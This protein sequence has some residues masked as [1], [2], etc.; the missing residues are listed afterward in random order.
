MN[1]AISLVCPQRA[2]CVLA[3]FGLKSKKQPLI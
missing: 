2:S 1:Q 3:A